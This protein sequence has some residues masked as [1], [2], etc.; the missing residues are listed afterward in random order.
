MVLEPSSIM[1]AEK[2]VRMDKAPEKRV[3]LHMHTN[4]SSMDALTCVGAKTDPKI[5]DNAIKRLEMW[6]H[7]A[8]ALTD[9]GVAHAFPN[10]WHSAKSLKILY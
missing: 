6:G 10:A 7:K 4:S 8:V 1:V 9:H 3:E 5:M 2:P